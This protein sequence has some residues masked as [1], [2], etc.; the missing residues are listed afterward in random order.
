MKIGQ[1]LYNTWFPR[2][3]VTLKTNVNRE[4]GFIRIARMIN[5]NNDDTRIINW[6]QYIM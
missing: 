5:T 4:K 6:Q 3:D 2:D 1:W